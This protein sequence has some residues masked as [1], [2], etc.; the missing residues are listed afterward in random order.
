M[1]ETIKQL[2]DRKST[3][4]FEDREISA[5]IKQ[6][7]ITCAIQAPTAGNLMMYSIIDVT[8][9]AIKDRLSV[10][11]D[12]QAFIAQAKMVF[13][14]ASDFQRLYDIFNH[15]GIENARKPKESDMM[16]GF[17]DA[18][19]A[20]QNAVV[21]AHSLGIGSC[22]IG[23]IFENY[24]EI[25]KLLSLPDYVAPLGMLVFGYPTEQQKERAKPL[26][27]DS[28]F[29]VHNNNYKQLGREELTEMIKSNVPTAA[30]KALTTIEGY[31]KRI[32][33]FKVGSEFSLEMVRSIKAMLKKWE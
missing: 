33:D 18:M 20:A 23:D 21:A 14:F 8:D 6:E 15:A 11:C 27:Y 29:I 24:E 13:I 2:Y 19:C 4:L 3:R 16:L 1:N 25:V 9:Q 32:Y 31:G 30:A 10:L 22:Y 28:K 17:A 26:R 7:I 5:E 12:N